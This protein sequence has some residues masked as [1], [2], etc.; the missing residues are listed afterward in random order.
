MKPR[1]SVIIPSRNGLDTLPRAVESVLALP[2]AEI[3]VIVVDDGSTDG[4]GDWLA[5][6]SARDSRVIGL[7]RDSN[8]GVSAARNAGIGAA[9]AP[10]LGF[11]DAD[12]IW[13]PEPIARRLAWHE[14]HPEAVLSFAEYQ[15][16]LPD[17]TL[18]DRYA[19]YCPRFQRFMAG[20]TGIVPLG[21][22][23]FSL[24]AGENPVCTSSVMASRAAVL[25]AGCFDPG[26]R[27]AEDWDLWIRLAQHGAVAASTEISLYHADR[28]GSL[29]HRVAERVACMREVVRRHRSY[30]WRHAPGAAMAAASLLAQAEA[31]LALRQGRQWRAFVHNTAAACWQPSR[32]HARDAARS[33][34]VVAGLKA[35]LPMS[36]GRSETTSA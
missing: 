28:P 32:Q 15:T 5:N 10:V 20:K 27:Q 22:Q 4:T 36:H 12:D 6:V 16:L 24:L 13:H 25:Q 2:V 35:P 29:S 1:L 18:Q 21:E 33:A 23:A 8:H 34:L 19:A 30:A 17:G 14:A 9:R 31:E 7:R 26:L 11:L 3:E